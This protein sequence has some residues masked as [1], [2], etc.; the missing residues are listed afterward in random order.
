MPSSLTQSLHKFEM[1]VSLCTKTTA[2]AASVKSYSH[3]P[4]SA[5]SLQKRGHILL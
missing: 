3:N 2:G 5:A 1:T 4:V